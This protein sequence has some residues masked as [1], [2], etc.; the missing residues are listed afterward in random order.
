LNFDQVDEY[1]VRT[2]S[3][4]FRQQLRC[5]VIEGD[6]LFGSSADV[7]NYLH[8]DDAIAAVH[9]HETLVVDESL[10]G[11]DCE[12]L[13]AV[14]GWDCAGGYERLVYRVPNCPELSF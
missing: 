2:H 8:Q 10:R 5:T 14:I 13:K 1:V 9:G 4:F 12:H 3:G 11:V 7:K 6:L